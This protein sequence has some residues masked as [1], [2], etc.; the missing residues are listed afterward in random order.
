[1]LLAIDAGN[2]HIVFGSWNGEWKHVWRLSTDAGAT[3]DEIASFF[4]G[5]HD[6][7]H[8]VKYDK[9]ICANV[10]PALADTFRRFAER[11]LGLELNFLTAE[12]LPDLEIRYE[13]KSAVGADRLANALAVRDKYTLPA[14]VVDFGTA[15]TFD[16][17]GSSGEYLGGSILTGIQLSMDALFSRAAKLPKIE[18]AAPKAAIGTD[19]VST[20]QSGL[21]LGYAGA[22]DTLARRIRTELGGKASVIA[23][24]GLA[25]MFAS[26]CEEIEFVD[27]LLTLDGLRIVAE[28]SS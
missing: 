10:V 7:A 25:P 11:W 26:Q 20:L 5:L 12:S 8:P 4:F 3:E 2:T 28:R 23:T 13:P 27:E 1:M 15:T 24:G 17:V 21:V 19:T 16:A 9:A 22:I 18:L 14:I 6:S